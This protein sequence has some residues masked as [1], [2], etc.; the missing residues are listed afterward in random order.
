MKRR[1]ISVSEYASMFKISV[2]AVYQRIQRQTLNTRKENGK[3]Y[4]ILENEEIKPD[5][6]DLNDKVENDCK[7][8]LKLVKSQQ[9][10]I[11]RLT[12]ALEQAKSEEVQTLKAFIGE[13]KQLTAPKED[14]DIIDLEEVPKKKKKKKKKK[15]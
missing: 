7:D 13:M 3:V 6:N 1:L 5:L 11:K 15:K 14:N 8:L 10:E 9:K 2:Q 4:I 12:K